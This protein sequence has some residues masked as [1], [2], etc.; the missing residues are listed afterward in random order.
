[1]RP[2]M[3]LIV[4]LGNPG[5]RYRSSR[6]NIGFRCLDLM[7]RE[8]DIRLSDRR[9][10][11]VL[12]RGR[13]AGQEIVL[14]KPRTFMNNSGE[15]VAYLLTRFSAHPS[16][17]VVIYDDMELPLGAPAPFSQEHLG[18]V[19]P[20]EV[21][22]VDRWSPKLAGPLAGDVYFRITLLTLRRG[23]LRPT[24]LDRRI[25]LC[26]PAAG[27]SRRRSRLS[28]ELARTRETQAIY[29][30]QRD[31]EEDLIRLTL[32]RRQ[33]EVEEQLLAEESQRA[34]TLQGKP[35]V[36]LEQLQLERIA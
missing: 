7:A 15:G 10:K 25:A 8:W 19:Y 5:P 22:R 29:L 16:E 27:L 24:I 17:L 1:M 14:A 18:L 13:R 36:W 23:G 30:T 2:K 3:C 31:A 6:H 35:R 21:V 26:L 32:Q 33:A 12:G 11:V 20:G 9:A 28:G 4:G 34:I